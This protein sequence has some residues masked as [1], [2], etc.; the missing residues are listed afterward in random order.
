MKQIENG[1]ADFVV[2]THALV[3]S[4]VSFNNLALTVVDEE[5]K[6]GVTQ[7]ES[8]KEK[9]NA[10]V[11]SISM[12]ATPIP[13][14]LALAVFGSSMDVYNISTMP[15]RR[16]PVLTEV[17]NNDDGAFKFMLTQIKSGRQCYIVCPLITSEEKADL[18]E[19]GK[20]LPLTVEE[21]E[22][23][24]HIFFDKYNISIGVVT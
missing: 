22:R 6:F 8:L 3:S 2:G 15:R 19:D 24:A 13:R 23:K 7:R 21:A 14:S 5:H 12:S 11:H 10:G 18:K 17:V 16:K 4:S 9:A 1:E 20:P